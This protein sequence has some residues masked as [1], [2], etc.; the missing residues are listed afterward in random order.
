M[1]TK[2][3]NTLH[4]RTP[5]GKSRMI[6]EGDTKI[7]PKTWTFIGWYG[8][9]SEKGLGYYK[10]GFTNE[11]E[12]RIANAFHKNEVIKMKDK[13]TDIYSVGAWHDEENETIRVEISMED[14]SYFYAD[15]PAY[16]SE[17]LMNYGFDFVGIIFKTIQGHDCHLNAIECCGDCLR[18]NGYDVLGDDE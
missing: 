7:A 2:I 18:L 3:T 6:H 9:D 5:T 10:D 11:S 13:L 16:S 4:F 15:I 1:R 8:I 12:Q 17:L 14:D